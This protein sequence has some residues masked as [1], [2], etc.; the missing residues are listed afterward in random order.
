MSYFIDHNDIYSITAQWEVLLKINH[1]L[2]LFRQSF[3]CPWK[4]YLIQFSEDSRK[5]IQQ[6]HCISFPL[7]FGSR[8]K[9]PKSARFLAVN[10]FHAN[11]MTLT[12][13]ESWYLSAKDVQDFFSTCI[14]QSLCHSL[15]KFYTIRL[16]LI[17]RLWKPCVPN[18]ESQNKK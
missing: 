1:G 9:N 18:F 11:T 17:L 5:V 6:I 15:I 2:C 16:V 14:V 12:N 7:F 3:D 8:K 4:D 13:S 10:L